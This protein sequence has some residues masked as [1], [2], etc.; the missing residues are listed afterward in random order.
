[1]RNSQEYGVC[2]TPRNAPTANTAAWTASSA[3]VSGDGAAS[4]APASTTAVSV[5]TA[6]GPRG[7]MPAGVPGLL[8]VLD[9][10]EV[11]ADIGVSCASWVHVGGCGLR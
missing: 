6:R 10:V 4:S 5:A 11:L 1:V 7:S 9:G 8:D 2:W 3:T